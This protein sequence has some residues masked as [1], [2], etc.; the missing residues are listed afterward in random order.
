MMRST[1]RQLLILL[2]LLTLAAPRAASAS[3]ILFSASG[4]TAA[5]ILPTV[6][7]YRNALGTLNPNVA[8]SFGTGRRE[9]NWDGVPDALSAPNN[10]P[11][12]FFNVNS[13][14]G[15][16]FSTPG[17]GFQVSG[18]PAV[19][20]PA[21][22]SNIDP[23]YPSFF[24]PFS[25]PRLFTALGSTITDVNFFVPGST[26]PAT[27]SGFGAIFSDVDLANISS[28]QYFDMFGASL[29]TFFVPAISGN[30]TFSF[31]GVVFT[32]E[33]V[34]RA[35][36][37]SGNQILAPGNVSQDLVV[38][39]DF[40]YGEPSA[41]PEPATGLLIAIGLGGLYRARRRRSNSSARVDPT[42]RFV[43]E[44]HRRL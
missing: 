30:Q 8:G 4:L 15:V 27:T 31:L 32:T 13:P 34:A 28:I 44:G 21:E 14:R 25:Q 16:V 10:L 39:D 19:G 42:K 20:A 41:I 40:I 1:P 2:F 9:I 26:S 37:T 43:R 17:T 24:E 3:A 29:G 6:N 18:N 38:M 12:N 5:D 11:A 33:Q 36:I 7:D 23:N 35:R 22:F